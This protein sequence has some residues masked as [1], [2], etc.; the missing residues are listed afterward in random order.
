MSKGYAFCEYADVSI[1][2]SVST[3]VVCLFLILEANSNQ[4]KLGE[5]KKQAIIVKFRKISSS[6]L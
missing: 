4:F 3:Q 1:T 2:D 6:S 5:Q